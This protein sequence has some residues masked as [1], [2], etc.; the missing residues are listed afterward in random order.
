M[1]GIYLGNTRPASKKAIKEAIAMGGPFDVHVESTSF[2]G[3]KS[4]R[5]DE[6]LPNVGDKV[7]FVGPDPYISRRFYGTITRTADGFK[8]A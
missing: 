1:D 4:G 8:V 3:G 7:A 5:L 6:V 2:F